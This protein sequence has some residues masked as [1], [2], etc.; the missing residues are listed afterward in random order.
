MSLCNW[1]CFLLLIPATSTQQSGFLA[2]LWQGI[3]WDRHSNALVCTLSKPASS[4]LIPRIQQ[5]AITSCTQNTGPIWG[6][7]SLHIWFY[8]WKKVVQMVKNLP[9][10][11]RPRFNPWVE[12]I[13]W[14]REQ[15]PTP[16][17]L[18]RESQGQRSLVGY[19]PWG[20]K[21]SDTTERL[22]LS[23]SISLVP[24]QQGTTP[25]SRQTESPRE[26]HPQLFPFWQES[27]SI[28]DHN[29]FLP[30]SHNAHWYSI[31]KWETE[32]REINLHQRPINTIDWGSFSLNMRRQGAMEILPSFS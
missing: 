4:C 7:F 21:E 30:L 19:S 5:W 10:M 28:V 32:L 15:L 16:L 24:S 12:K 14:R 17:F 6:L 23:I 3:S 9:A 18:P 20:C 22:T 26:T 8:E 11:Q 2:R 27:Q 31:V 13:P 1:F 29:S 25:I